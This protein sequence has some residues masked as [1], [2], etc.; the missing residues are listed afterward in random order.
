MRAD[1]KV[2]LLAISIA[3]LL[4]A[5]VVLAKYTAA[6][7]AV[8]QQ[9]GSLLSVTG[10]ILTPIS[11]SSGLGIGCLARWLA[12]RCPDCTALKFAKSDDSDVSNQSVSG[13]ATLTS[14]RS[15]TSKPKR[16]ETSNVLYVSASGLLHCSEHCAGA[17]HATINCCGRCMTR[18]MKLV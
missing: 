9:C 17:S 8:P 16:T 4:V 11:F 6:T 10:Y 1:Q 15:N 14:K 7:T 3:V 2:Q 5:I 12:G 18:I 13:C